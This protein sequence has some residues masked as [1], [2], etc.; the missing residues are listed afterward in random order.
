MAEGD[1][2][3][4]EQ[5]QAFVALLLRIHER[6]IRESGGVHGVHASLLSAAVARPFQTFDQR[7]FYTTPYERAAALVHAIICDHVFADGN[8]RT[9]TVA[10]F[11]YLVAF[12]EM[13]VLQADAAPSLLVSLVGQVA[14]ETARGGM[15]V[16]DVAFWLERIL[17]PRP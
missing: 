6:I 17:A 12:E 14:L 1:G 10:A 4:V 13:D 2:G 3:Q 15:A 8:K 9:A 5:L 7:L 11:V 16:E